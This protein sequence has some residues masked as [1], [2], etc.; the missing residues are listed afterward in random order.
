MADRYA[1]FFGPVL[2]Q[3]ADAPDAVSFEELRRIQERRAELERTREAEPAWPEHRRHE[4]I[5]PAPNP[6]HGMRV[7]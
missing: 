4:T 2:P 1:S 5:L 3:A 6:R 7:A